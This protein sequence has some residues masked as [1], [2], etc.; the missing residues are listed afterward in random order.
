MKQI[1]ILLF[2]IPLLL[3]AQNGPT[4]SYLINPVCEGDPLPLNA[5]FSTP[6][7]TTNSAIISWNWQ[8]NGSTISSQEIGNYTFSQ[9]GTYDVTLTVTD[10]DGLSDDT[11]FNIQIFCPP[12][13][14]FINDVVCLG[15]PTSFVDVTTPG[16][17]TPPLN[18]GSSWMYQFGNANPPSAVNPT[19]STTFLD[20]GSNEVLYIVSEIQWNGQYCVDSIVKFVQVDSCFTGIENTNKFKERKIIKNLDLLGKSKK[21]NSKNLNIIIYDDGRIDKKYIIE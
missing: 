10:A 8:Y 5:S 11:I 20:A 15:N 6:N 17:G 19:T 3:I 2:S 16:D 9:C 12:I 21:I 13:A 7:P 1:L 18:S 4:A 14:D